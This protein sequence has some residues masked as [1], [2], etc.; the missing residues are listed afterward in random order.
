MFFYVHTNIH[1]YYM[2]EYRTCVHNRYIHTY[3]YTKS[4]QEPA[5]SNC[6]VH[7]VIFIWRYRSFLSN[8]FYLLFSQLFVYPRRVY[9]TQIALIVILLTTYIRSTFNSFFFF[10]DFNFFREK[11]TGSFILCCA[12]SAGTVAP[13]A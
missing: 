13:N 4:E 7:Q 10:P 8:L 1:L 12:M 3:M 6:H 9:G 2:L 11:S 5:N